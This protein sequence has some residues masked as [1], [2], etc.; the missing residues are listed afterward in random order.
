MKLDISKPLGR[1]ILIKTEK[2]PNECWIAFSYERLSNFCFNCDCIGHLAKDCLVP[3]HE[4]EGEYES[5]FQ[6]GP[7]MRFSRIF[8][9]PNNS[10]WF[11]RHDVTNKTPPKQGGLVVE[12]HEKNSYRRE[13]KEVFDD[14][15]DELNVVGW[16]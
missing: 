6:Y 4:S 11:W 1:S 2:I 15:H 5:Y 7:W 10:S 3:K 12:P 16:F 8:N 13:G 14:Q 9:M